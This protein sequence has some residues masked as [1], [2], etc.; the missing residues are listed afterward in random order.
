MAHGSLPLH[1][2]LGDVQQLGDL[3]G[4]PE[5]GLRGLQVLRLPHLHGDGLQSHLLHC[6]IAI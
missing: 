6:I 4:R 1:A 2:A 3:V 5:E